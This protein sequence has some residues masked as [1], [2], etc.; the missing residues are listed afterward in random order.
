ML[1]ISRPGRQSHFVETC[2]RNCYLF[3]KKY[4]INK[5]RT[6]ES[7]DY[8]GGRMMGVDERIAA[9]EEENRKLKDD[10][11]RLM[12]IIAQMKTTL[13]RLLDRYMMKE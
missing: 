5:N 8:K 4:I 7:M 6:C 3:P 2:D 13:N 1:W 9:L 12:K 10:N 11:E